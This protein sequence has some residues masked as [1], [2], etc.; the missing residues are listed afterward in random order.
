MGLSREEER[1]VLLGGLKGGRETS[2]GHLIR[3]R[4]EKVSRLSLRSVWYSW[5]TELLRKVEPP[6]WNCLGPP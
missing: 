1:D 2:S 4:V 6:S 3:R 5:V